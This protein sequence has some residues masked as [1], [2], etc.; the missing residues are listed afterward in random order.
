[1]SDYENEFKMAADTDLTCADCMF[2]QKNLKV[3]NVVDEWL[4]MKEEAAQNGYYQRTAMEVSVAFLCSRF[5][6]DI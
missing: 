3:P 4:C 6:L 1:M 2:C 5:E